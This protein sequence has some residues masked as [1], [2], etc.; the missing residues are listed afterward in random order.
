MHSIRWIHFSVAARTNTHTNTHTKW[1]GMY[2]HRRK[3]LTKNLISH[4]N[5]NGAKSVIDFLDEWRKFWYLRDD[6]NEL[7]QRQWW[8]G[9]V[10]STAGKCFSKLECTVRVQQ[11]AVAS[12]LARLT[13]SRS[14]FPLG[15]FEWQTPSLFPF[16]F[17]G[18][19]FYYFA[20][21]LRFR[22]WNSFPEKWITNV[23]ISFCIR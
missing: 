3:F 10:Q 14:N 11:N 8:P 9:G 7:N 2:F 13:F 19:R 6:G 17:A 18:N 23:S 22:S 4:R 21:C 16:P 15:D 12:Q 20:S 5:S 1:Q